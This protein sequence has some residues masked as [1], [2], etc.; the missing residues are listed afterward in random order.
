VNLDH[1]LGEPDAIVQEFFELVRVYGECGHARSLT[2]RVS[3]ES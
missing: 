2:I 1:L 3:E